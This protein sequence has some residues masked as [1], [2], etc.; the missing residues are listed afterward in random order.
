[1]NIELW[2][3]YI[4]LAVLILL[5]FVSR[6]FP[7]FIP[8][9]NIDPSNKILLES[10]DLAFESETCSEKPRSI[11]ENDVRDHITKLHG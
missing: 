3:Y 2:A 1:M 4:N 10:V 11:E 6:F 9:E 5:L 7:K 8:V